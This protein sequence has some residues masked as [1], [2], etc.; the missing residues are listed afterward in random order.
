MDR[1]SG[2]EWYLQPTQGLTTSQ[3]FHRCG[4]N[5]SCARRLVLGD[6]V[7]HIR[8][9]DGI[10]SRRGVVILG[11]GMPHV[12]RVRVVCHVLS[13]QHRRVDLVDGHVVTAIIWRHLVGLSNIVALRNHVHRRRAS[14]LRHLLHGRTH[15]R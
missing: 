7:L 1:F 10:L 14:I 12:H 15:G 2:Y 4:L 5:D 9:L 8:V 11:M 13:R 3:A 6:N